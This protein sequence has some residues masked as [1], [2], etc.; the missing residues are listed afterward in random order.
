MLQVVREVCQALDEFR[1]E[2]IRNPQ[3]QDAV[4]DDFQRNWS[5][6]ETLRQHGNY[7]EGL[8]WKENVESWEE[9]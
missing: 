7:S 6:H 5:F 9:K 4:A 3:T 2:F 8:G 1:D